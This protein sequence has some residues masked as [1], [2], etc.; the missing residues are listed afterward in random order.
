MS[1]PYKPYLMTIFS[2]CILLYYTII[3]IVVIINNNDNIEEQFIET[4]S[5][6]AP[7]PENRKQYPINV[8]SGIMKS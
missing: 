3:N 1:S 5:V 6:V 4:V 7:N 2:H 8:M